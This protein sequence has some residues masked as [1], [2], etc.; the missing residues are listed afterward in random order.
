[1]KNYPLKNNKWGPF[2]EDVPGWSDTQINAM[3]FARFIMEHRE[4]FPQW[5]ENVQGII[6]WVYGRLG[7]KNWEKYGV[8]VIN[9]QTAYEVQGTVIG[10]K[11]GTNFCM[12]GSRAT[13]PDLLKLLSVSLYGQ[14]YGRERW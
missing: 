6:R 8:T 4:Y 9:E 10:K 12:S 3:T 5:R 11:G 1:M 2:F 7:N 13:A 14:H